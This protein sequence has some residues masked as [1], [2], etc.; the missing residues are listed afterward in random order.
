MMID[1]KFEND[2]LWKHMDPQEI[3]QIEP[4]NTDF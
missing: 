2:N 1:F 4:I 3:E